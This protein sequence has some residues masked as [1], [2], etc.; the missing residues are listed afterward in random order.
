M[1]WEILGKETDKK[2]SQV[3]VWHSDRLALSPGYTF[4]LR[5]FAD[6]ADAGNSHA[7]TLWSDS[8]CGIVWAEIEKTVVGII[9]YD[10]QYI[11]S[12][13]P[14]LAIQ[15]TAVK[16]EFRQRNIHTIMNKYFEDTARKLGCHF[17]R[18]T[19]NVKNTARLITT[20]KDGLVPRLVVLNK[21]IS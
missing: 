8:N 16:K 11:H 2:E 20:K 7:A 15:L 21:D 19:V 4:F 6:L 5:E 18:A 17:T 9:V 3:T 14:Y 10:K 12:S 1:T 13:F